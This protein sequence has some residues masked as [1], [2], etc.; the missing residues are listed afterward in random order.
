M[1]RTTPNTP[2]LGAV[3]G[4]ESDAV[5]DVTSGVEGCDNALLFPD[6]QEV[7]TEVLCGT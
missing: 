5:F 1:T 6:T 2:D 3:V 7:L 4:A